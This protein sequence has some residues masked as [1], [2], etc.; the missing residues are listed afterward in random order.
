MIKAKTTSVAFRVLLVALLFVTTPSSAWAKRAPVVGYAA[1]ESVGMNGAYLAQMIDS[2]VNHSIEE[3]CFPGC[4]VLVARRGKIVF[5]KSYGYHTYDCERRV[6]NHHLYDMASCTKVLASTLCM[7]RLVEQ[8]KIDLDKPF[9][10]YFD[11][12]KGT[13]KEAMTLRE[14]MTHQSGLRSI[15]FQRA[16]WDENRELRSDMFSRVPSEDFPYQFHDSLWVCKDTHKRLYDR[17]VELKNGAKKLRYTCTSFHF[18]PD[19]IKRIT[20]CYFEEFL[21]KEFYEPLG[22]KN[23]LFNPRKTHSLDEIVPTE[24]D[25][26]Y[27]KGLV[28]G[29]VHDEAAA[30]LGG[31]SGN[32]GLF[33]NAESLVPILQ[34]L[35]NGGEYNGVRYF[36]RK[37]IREWTSVQYP[38]NNNHRGIGFDKRRFSDDRT[39]KKPDLKRYYYAPSASKKSFGHSGFTGTMIWVDPKKD[40]IFIFLSNRVHPSRDNKAFSEQNPRAKCHEAAYEAQRRK[41]K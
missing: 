38:K 23:A 33:A 8:G 3:R 9:S 11:E 21:C 26:Y 39:R 31:V 34:M 27:R 12:L 7:M 2:I 25:N 29:F 1:P 40:L 15:S 30:S 17:I 28:H 6:E 22:V 10:D 5:N 4:Q 19:A 41:R 18:Y 37:T 13:D 35:L 32:A 14:M 36:K 16:F 24:I 20:G